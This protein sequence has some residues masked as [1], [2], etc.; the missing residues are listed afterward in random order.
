MNILVIGSGA[1]ESSIAINL[2]K[3]E[4]I[5]DVYISPGNAGVEFYNQA[6]KTRIKQLTIQESNF[7]EI[8]SFSINNKIDFVILGSEVPIANGL[9]DF[10][11]AKG[12]SVI[13]PS[14]S[15]SILETSKIWAK[16][17]AKEF[18]IP[19]PLFFVPKNQEETLDILNNISF[20]IFIK[21]DALRGGKG[22]HIVHNKNEY[23]AKTKQFLKEKNKF[24]IE[25]YLVGEELSYFI[26][27]GQNNEY[28]SLP[29]ARDF[30]RQSK[31]IYSLNTGGM[32]SESYKSLINKDLKTKIEQTVKKTIEGLNTRKIE[33][34]G[35][36]YFGFMIKD[37]IPYLLEYNVRLGDPETQV[38]LPALDNIFFNILSSSYI[39]VGFRQYEYADN[40]SFGLVISQKSYPL[41]TEEQFIDNYLNFL[42]KTLE[43]KKAGIDIIH[44]GTKLKVN[45]LYAVSG[46]VFTL[47]AQG[48]TLKEAKNKIKKN[49]NKILWDGAY[50]REDLLV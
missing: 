10:L 22:S 15:A 3:N 14:K 32:G 2:S 29:Y 17:F 26:L 47:V 8:A 35:F 4:N 16:E 24:L 44:S 33:Y 37:N 41:K 20:P 38:I 46:R 1:R 49:L 21:E 50:Y 27:L 13:A 31:D 7:D 9:S 34:K 40:I 45:N 43:L 36:L 12:I 11:Q 25:E 30:K 23:L 28:V 19:I 48:K 5:K 18:N 39:G 6:Y 42:Q